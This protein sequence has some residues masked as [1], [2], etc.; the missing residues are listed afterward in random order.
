L[1]DAEVALHATAIVYDWLDTMGILVLLRPP[2]LPDLVS[3][4]FSL[5]P[6][7]KKE[8]ENHNLMAETIKT[9]LDG[10]IRS[11]AA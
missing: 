9:T 3:E 5:F 10:V 6:K 4:S 11:V 2:C 8:L 1:L 7:L